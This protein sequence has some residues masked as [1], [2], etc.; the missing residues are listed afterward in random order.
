MFI[1]HQSKDDNSVNT[2]KC[3]CDTCDDSFIVQCIVK[4]FKNLVIDNV[5]LLQALSDDQN[6]KFYA[7]AHKVWSKRGKRLFF[8][9]SRDFFPENVC[10]ILKI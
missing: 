3:V 4:T 8:K 5:D 7:L 2:T 10:F 1:I 6:D 9:D